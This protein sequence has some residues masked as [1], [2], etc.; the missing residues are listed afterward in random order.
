ME[1]AGSL[2]C[3]TLPPIEGDRRPHHPA[4]PLS[5]ACRCVE[6]WLYFA[7]SY[8]ATMM[9]PSPSFSGDASEVLGD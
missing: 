4:R 3:S 9:A 6:S 1:P 2:H 7:T 8:R 5:F